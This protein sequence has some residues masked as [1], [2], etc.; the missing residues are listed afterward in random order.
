L[1]FRPLIVWSEKFK[2]EIEDDDIYPNSWF[3]NLLSRAEFL[4]TMKKLLTDII[5]RIPPLKIYSKQPPM[6]K[7][8]IGILEFLSH[9]LE[10]AFYALTIYLTFK[11][12]IYFYQTFS[13]IEV[14]IALKLG[15]ITAFKVL[16]AV[17]ISALLWI[18]VGVIIGSN[19]RLALRIQPVFQFLAACPLQMFYPAVFAL[20]IRY[21]LNVDIWT[22]PLMIIG[23][24]WY[25]LFNAIAG[26]MM[27]TKDQRLVAANFG[28]KG[29]LLW[30][31]LYLPAVMPYCIT[32]CITAAGGCWNISMNTD[33]VEW[34][35]IKLQA[36]GISSYIQQAINVGSFDKIVLGMAVMAF[37]VIIINR[38]LWHPLFEKVSAYR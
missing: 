4:R 30:R 15:A 38:L 18:P 10:M 27:I 28:L 2:E 3:F 17:L 33:T 24:Q 1:V 7:K 5:E 8:A 36:I 37:Y 9:G 12:S 34:G 20:I 19:S 13:L 29:W 25:I 32:G 26:S 31:R 6:I 23:T 21:K 14:L 35:S 22:A 16:I 11:F